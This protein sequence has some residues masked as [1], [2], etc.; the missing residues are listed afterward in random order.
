MIQ[1]SENEK[2]G[3]KLLR[4]YSK[5][6]VGQKSIT[7]Q[8]DKQLKSMLSTFHVS[9]VAN[10]PAAGKR[11]IPPFLESIGGDIPAAHSKR[12]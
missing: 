2:V 7:Q 3:T 4:L 5:E 1:Q 10:A 9:V 11:K 6:G 8:R 12:K